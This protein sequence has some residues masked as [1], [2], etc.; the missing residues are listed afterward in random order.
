MNRALLDKQTLRGYGNENRKKHRV[1][2]ATNM[3]KWMGEQEMGEL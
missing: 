3:C 1:T 2:Y